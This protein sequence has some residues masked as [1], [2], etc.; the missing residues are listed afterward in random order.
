M[1]RRRSRAPALSRPQ[2]S[3]PLAPVPRLL[4]GSLFVLQHLVSDGGDLP[5]PLPDSI[6]VGATGTGFDETISSLSIL[7]IPEPT[8]L[9]MLLFGGLL[10]LKRRR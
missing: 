4:L 3:N 8:T 10:A 1:D 9:S 6:P 7:A 2:V 5:S